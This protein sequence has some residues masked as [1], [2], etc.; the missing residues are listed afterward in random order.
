MTRREI[1][2]HIFLMLFRKDFHN[3]QDLLEQVEIYLSQLEEATI[4]ERA[5]LDKRFSAILE[6]LTEIDK[7]LST[8]ASSWTLD[9]M[10]KVEL[11][12]LR[13]AVYEMHFDEDIPVKVAINEAVE[14]AKGFGGDETPGF[15]NGVLAKLT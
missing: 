10:G 6:K 4:E 13:L 12:V 11:T 9:R 3:S 8:S 2:E 15:V 14:L 5:Y 1:R 7:M